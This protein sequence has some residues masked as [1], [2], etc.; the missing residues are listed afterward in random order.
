MV[1]EEVLK[2]VD[3]PC[4]PSSLDGG[5]PGQWSAPDCCFRS[6]REVSPTLFYIYI[7]THA[8]SLSLS[9]SLSVSLSL[10]LSL[11][12]PHFSLPLSLCIMILTPPPPPT[13]PPS[14]SHLCFTYCYEICSSLIFAFVFFSTSYIYDAIQRY[15]VH[16]LLF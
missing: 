15:Y 12:S 14:A 13:H 2:N 11:S 7:V 8:L 5:Q 9:L 16:V 4:A 10:S 3:V 6:R 1:K